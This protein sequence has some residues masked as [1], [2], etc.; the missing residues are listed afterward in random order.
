MTSVTRHR[1]IG[2]HS[3]LYTP[4]A[5]ANAVIVLAHGAGAAM[6]SPFMNTLANALAQQ[7]FDVA[8]FEFPYMQ[9]RRH[10]GVKKPPNRMPVLVEHWARVLCDLAAH[11]TL[12][13]IIG[14]KSMGGRAA[15]MLLSD[16]DGELMTRRRL[17]GGVCFG[18]PFH[19][20]G[21]P[22]TLRVD[23][24][25][26]LPLPLVIFQGERDPFGKPEEVAG[27]SLDSHVRVH[28]LSAADHDFKPLRRSGQTQDTVIDRV[29]ALTAAAF[30]A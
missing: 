14:G 9:D 15:T 29:A 21:K 16:L 3:V 13:V 10:T 30:S 8:R 22:E 4:A 27:Y 1:Q 20:P 5:R 2:D 23:H 25:Q 11:S 19:P 26:K 17:L 24:L 12:P 18:Y 7:Q 28:W 6:D